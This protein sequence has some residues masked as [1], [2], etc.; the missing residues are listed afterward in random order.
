MRTEERSEAV[1]LAALLLT[2][3]LLFKTFWILTSVR[4]RCDEFRYFWGSSAVLPAFAAV[5]ILLTLWAAHPL[6]QQAVGLRVPRT[7]LLWSLACTGF[8]LYFA[9]W[10]LLMFAFVHSDTTFGNAIASRLAF[11]LPDACEVHR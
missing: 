7:T 11:S 3:G 8:V 2:Y 6:L 4:F 10:L 1:T 5:A 9:S